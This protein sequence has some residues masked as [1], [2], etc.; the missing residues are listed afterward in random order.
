MR[1]WKSIYTGLRQTPE[2][3]RGGGL[4]E[5]VGRCWSINYQREHTTHSARVLFKL[6]REKG[7]NDCLVL[8]GRIVSTG[9]SGKLKRKTASLKFFCPEARLKIL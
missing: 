9:G 2:N 3:D 1:V 7:M 6:L 5:D 4:A 8:V